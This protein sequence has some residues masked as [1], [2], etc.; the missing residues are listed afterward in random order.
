MAR[1]MIRTILRLRSAKQNLSP[2][3]TNEGQILR[4]DKG[5]QLNGRRPTSSCRPR[6]FKSSGM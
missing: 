3:F 6:I 5:G 4:N 2:Q 1:K